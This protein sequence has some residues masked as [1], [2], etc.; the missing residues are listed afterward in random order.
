MSEI[1]NLRVVIVEPGKPAREA[2]IQDDLHSLQQVVDGFIEFTYPFD[3]NACVMGNDEAKLLGMKGTAKI[4]GSVYCG[5]IV[6]VGDDYEGNLTDLTDE[7]VQ[8][9]LEMFAEP[10]EISDDDIAND[11]SFTIWSW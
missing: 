11:M 9:Y 4:N 5:P 8:K 2:V 6:I 7:Q 10:E 3:D 1:K